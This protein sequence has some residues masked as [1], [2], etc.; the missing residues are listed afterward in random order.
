MSPSLLV[1]MGWLILAWPLN[2]PAWAAKDRHDPISQKIDRERRTLDKLKKEI[3]EKQHQ[4]KAVEKQKES[5]VQ[6]IHDLDNRL[7]RSRSDYAA[8]TKNLKQKDKALADI[9]DNLTT[10]RE[11]I[12]QRRGSILAR[13]RVQYMEGRHASLRAVLASNSYPEFQRR[14][15]YLSV[16]SRREYDLIEAY[17]ADVGALETTEQQLE[18]ARREVLATKEQTERQL[19][20]IKGLKHDKRVILA[21]IVHEKEAYDRA[22]EDLQ[23]SA[24]RVDSLLKELE[25]RKHVA[26]ARPRKDIRP[27]PPSKGIF[28]WPADGEVVSYF[29]RHRHPTFDTYVQHKGI[30]IRAA[31]GAAIRSVSDGTVAYA[32]WL[33]GYGLVLILDHPNGFFSL[34]AHALKLLVKVGEQ[35]RAGQI[36]GEAGDTGMTGEST[37]YF[38]LR[39]GAEPVDPLAWLARRG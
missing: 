26:L 39:D 19:A 37:L 33:K 25:G 10:L 38:E 27:I 18:V 5:V 35:V 28:Q 8:I 11:R 31:E 4:A 13:V 23:R 30:E 9:T 32:D 2:Q 21:K 22:L 20:E 36:I 17:R 3:K 6:V 7:H 14:A 29:G 24:G 1:L 34:Y 15:K 12:Q 16:A